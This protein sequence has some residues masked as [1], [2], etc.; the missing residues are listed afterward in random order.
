[1]TPTIPIG[2]VGVVSAILAIRRP[3][4][5]RAVAVWALVIGSVSILYSA[6]WLLFTA[7]RAN[8]FG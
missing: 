7:L 6:G 3:L 2:L 8:F 1:M 5:S 4:E